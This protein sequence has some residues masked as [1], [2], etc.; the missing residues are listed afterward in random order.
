MSVNVVTVCYNERETITR[1]L[2]SVQ[3]QSYQAIRHIVIDG[4]STDGTA[5]I[6]ASRADSLH[7]QISE[8]DEGIY[9]AMNKALAHCHDDIVYFLNA[10]D[11]FFS[12]STVEQAVERF[13]ADP[14]IEILSGRVRYFNTPLDNGVPYQR[15]DFSYPTKLAYFRR[16]VPQ[17]CL[18]VR[19]E[20]FTTLGKFDQRYAM[21]ADFEWLLRAIN[22]GRN[23]SQVDDVFCHFD[24]QGVSYTQNRQRRWEKNLAIARNATIADQARYAWTALSEWLGKR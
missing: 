10:D 5:E 8:P 11:Y 9:S 7:L 18:F 6:I 2:D 13:A 23:I 24:Y 21:C 20:L 4:A 12:G 17:Q 15:E 19:R 16:G 3:S 14:T 22:D 1:C